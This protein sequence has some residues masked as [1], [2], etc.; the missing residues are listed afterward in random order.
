MN[1]LIA[2]DDGINARGIHELAKALSRVA[3]IYISAPDSQRSASGHGITMGKEIVARKTEFEY[4]KAAYSISGTPANSIASN[5]ISFAFVTVS[6]I[7][8]FP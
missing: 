2:N 4:A 1:I 7:L 3:D 5:P 6:N 8:I